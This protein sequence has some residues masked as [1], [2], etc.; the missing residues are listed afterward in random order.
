LPS[1]RQLK[2]P[3]LWSAS[4]CQFAYRRLQSRDVS[5]I[6]GCCTAVGGQH[7]RQQWRPGRLC[8]AGGKESKAWLMCRVR[9]ASR[10]HWAVSRAAHRRL[11]WPPPRGTRLTHPRLR[12]P[13]HGWGD[14]SSGG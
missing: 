7:H 9:E 4:A 10:P 1:E 14:A 8:L 2:I 13:G 11:R 6:R 5:R 12:T 3:L